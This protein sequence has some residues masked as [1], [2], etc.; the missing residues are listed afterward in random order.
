MPSDYDVQN[1]LEKKKHENN[2][3]IFGQWEFSFLGE[4]CLLVFAGCIY[5]H[6]ILVTGQSRD[7][8]FQTLVNS[9]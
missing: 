3:K 1:N 9:L 5:L 7:V 4:K 6:M 8:N 2:K